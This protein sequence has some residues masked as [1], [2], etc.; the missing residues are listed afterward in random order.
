MTL[1]RV[2]RGKKALFMWL[3]FC[4]KVFLN[5][6]TRE[7][8]VILKISGWRNWSHSTYHRLIAVNKT[9]KMFLK[10]V[11]KI[12]IMIMG[13]LFVDKIH[14][15]EESKGSDIVKGFSISYQWVGKS[16]KM[17]LLNFKTSFIILNLLYW[18]GFH[19][20]IF[21]F[22]GFF[23]SLT[24]RHLYCDWSCAIGEILLYIRYMLK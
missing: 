24:Y 20:V 3:G 14:M 11:S 19:V 2:S 12:P 13:A 22:L 16:R 23:T 15:I 8:Q 7:L 4:N 18:D 10:T 5:F 1:E 17:F 21:F 6:T 9:F